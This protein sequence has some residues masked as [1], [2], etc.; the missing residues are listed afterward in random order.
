MPGFVPSVR[1]RA[2][3]L[4]LLTVL[5]TAASGSVACAASSPGEQVPASGQQ[6]AVAFDGARAL[7][8]AEAMAAMGPRPLGSEALERNRVYI[9]QQLEAL[10][11][12]AARDEFTA[13]TPIGAVAMANILADVP[14]AAGTPS[15]RV[16]LLGGHY[17]TKPVEG[18]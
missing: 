8:H 16:L 4:A 10:G 11:I 7:G 18:A 14:A 5:A 2:P 12:E 15:G 6:A 1:C 9:E 13:G 3:V 17:D